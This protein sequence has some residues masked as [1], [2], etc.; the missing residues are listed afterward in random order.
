MAIAI[1]AVIGMIA[2]LLIDHGRSASAHHEDASA[3]LPDSPL[4]VAHGT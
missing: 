3:E 4:P 1:P 2:V